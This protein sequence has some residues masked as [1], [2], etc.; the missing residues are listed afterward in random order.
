[1]VVVVVDALLEEIGGGGG[2]G[3]GGG[4]DAAVAFPIPP[5]RWQATAQMLSEGRTR[6]QENRD[7]ADVVMEGGAGDESRGSSEGRTA[8][9]RPWAALAQ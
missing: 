2:G 3:C 8:Q 7:E 4:R 5:R 1:M 9:A 6:K